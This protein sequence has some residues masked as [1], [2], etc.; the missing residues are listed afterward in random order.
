MNTALHSVV[1]TEH[2]HS[3]YSSATVNNYFSASSGFPQCFI[4]TQSLRLFCY[5]ITRLLFIETIN[6]HDIT[7]S[8]SIGEHKTIIFVIKIQDAS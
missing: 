6:L 2:F 1:L 3:E 4:W 8:K 5:R 7:I